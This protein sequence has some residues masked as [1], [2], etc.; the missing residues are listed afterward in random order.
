MP[1][2]ENDPEYQRRAYEAIQRRAV[3]E[4]LANA[5]ELTP[6]AFATVCMLYVDGSI[7]GVKTPIFVDSG[8]QMSVISEKFAERCNLTRLIDRRHQGVARGVGS[9]KIVGVVHLAVV[10]IGGLALPMRLTVLEQDSMEFLLGLD[11]L[12][13]HEM[14]I[15]LSREDNCLMI[16]KGEDQRKAPFLSQHELPEHLR[17]DYGRGGG[18]QDSQDSSGGM[19]MGGR[20]SSTDAMRNASASA[21]DVNRQLAE[22]HQQ[23]QQQ[24]PQPANADAAAPPASQRQQ[25]P[26]Q[27]QVG[28]ALTAEQRGKIDSLC[29]MLGAQ[30]AMALQALQACDWNMDAA[31]AILMSE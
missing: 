18:E 6:E 21:A 4:N 17:Q 30:P 13:K 8:A 22:R 9:T 5:L 16:G 10:T 20:A 12:R 7:N 14:T 31:A 2:D 29:S 3:E 25:Q 11:Q 23:Q 24:Q 1:V 15:C 26:Q 27:Q 28:V 19:M